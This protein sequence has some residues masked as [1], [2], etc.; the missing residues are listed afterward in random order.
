MACRIDVAIPTSALHARDADED[1]LM[2]I[3]KINKGK[4][5]QAG[6]TRVAENQK[7]TWNRS[8]G[9]PTRPADVHAHQIHDS[10]GPSQCPTLHPKRLDHRIQPFVHDRCRAFSSYVTLRR[11]IFHRNLPL[12]VGGGSGL[13]SNSW[14]LGLTQLTTP[15]DILIESAVFPQYTFV[16]NG[17]TDR[18]RPREQSRNSACKNRPITL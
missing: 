13:A 2:G 4:I 14:F 9:A 17:R 3:I 1:L 10:F 5:F 7:I 12:T 11:S 6:Q 18:D 16:I 8:Q 15:N